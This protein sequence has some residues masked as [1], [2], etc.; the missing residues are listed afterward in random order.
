MDASRTRRP[1]A[2]AQEAHAGLRMS[3]HSPIYRPPAARHPSADS[4]GA[5]LL[6]AA[7][8]PSRGDFLAL[9]RLLLT[10]PRVPLKPVASLGS[11]SH[12]HRP[13]H[14]SFQNVSNIFLTS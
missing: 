11:C 2:G 10:V 4:L 1:S 13:V 8:A 14:L 6:R 9:W 3:Q 12:F 7:A 5:A